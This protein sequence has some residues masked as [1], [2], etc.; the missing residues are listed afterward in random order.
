MAITVHTVMNLQQKP[1]SMN[2]KNTWTFTPGSLCS[3]TEDLLAWMRALH[4]KSAIRASMYQL[5]D[6]PEIDGLQDGHKYASMPKAWSTFQI[7]DTG[8]L[9]MRSYI[10]GI[11]LLDTRFFPGQD[12]ETRCLIDSTVDLKRAHSFASE[13]TWKLVF[14]Q[15][16][17]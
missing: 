7:W 1:Y 9:V 12:L 16:G 14:Q 5:N 4:R 15:K 11:S 6:Y 3:T 13:I 17:I 2:Q 8:K 10:N